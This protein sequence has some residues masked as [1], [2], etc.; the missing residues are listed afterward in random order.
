MLARRQFL[1]FGGSVLVATATLPALARASAPS[2]AAAANFAALE[3]HSGGRLGVCLWHPASGARFGHRMEERF[4]MCSTF[5]F[6]LVAAVLHRAGHGGLSLDQRVP[7]RQADILHHSPVS[8][9]HVGKDMSVRDLCRATLT[10]SD[11]AAANLLLPLVGAPAGLTAFLRGQGDAVTVAA[12]REPELNSFAPGDPRDTTSPA[13]MAGNLQRFVLGDALG[14]IPRRQ[15]ADWL[16]DNE[17][18]DERLRAGLP[19]GWRVGDKTGSGYERDGISNDIAVLWPPGAG[20]PWLLAAY[21]QGATQD[22]SG[23]NGIL[24]RAAELAAAHLR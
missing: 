6:P 15:L 19:Q 16:I 11:N 2:P 23:R 21:L 3:K 9:R 7:V 13:A 20:T 10:V 12:R 4:P 14:E 5:K 24:R 18:G 22:A 1:T 17:T 8:G